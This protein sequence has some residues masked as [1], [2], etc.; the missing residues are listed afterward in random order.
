MIWCCMGNND[1]SSMSLL[2][3]VLQSLK[4][5][6][7]KIAKHFMAMLIVLLPITTAIVMVMEMAW[8]AQQV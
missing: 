7:G 4:R 3:V 2:M 5:F 8:I 1:N 6:I